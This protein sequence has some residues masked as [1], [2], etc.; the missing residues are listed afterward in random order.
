VPKAP[1]K[2]HVVIHHRPH[3]N[4]SIRPK[5]PPAELPEPIAVPKEH[6]ARPG[7]LA[8]PKERTAEPPAPPAA[9]EPDCSAERYPLEEPTGSAH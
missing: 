5:E 6:S 1:K 8:V 9:P 3:S 4:E 7:P 2:P